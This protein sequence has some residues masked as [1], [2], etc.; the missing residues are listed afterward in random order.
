MAT[1][2]QL[3][4]TNGRKRTVLNLLTDGQLL[5]R[6][7]TRG[8][9]AAFS[10]LVTRH[11]PV[12]LSVCRR[13]LHHA[14]DSEDA[15]QATFLVL[16]R[17]ASSIAKRDSVASWL[18]KVAY[19]IA[20]RARA[21]K[22]RRQ[23]QERQA[24]RPGLPST[25]I[26]AASRE[27]NRVIDEEVQRLPEKYRTPI[28]LCYLQGQTNE[29]AAAR[30]HWPTGT[31]K[32]RLLRARELLRKRLVRRGLDLSAGALLVALLQSAVLAVPPALAAATL[33]AATIGVTS[34]PIAGLVSATL[35]GM[36]LTKLKVALVVL[37]T[38]LLGTLA[39]GLAQRAQAATPVVKQVIDKPTLPTPLPELDLPPSPPSF[40]DRWFVRS[41]HQEVGQ[42]A[43]LP[44]QPGRLATYPTNQFLSA[45]AVA[46]SCSAPRPRQ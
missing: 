35:K 12:V 38:V 2:L 29:E 41:D 11:G 26:E 21:D 46:A 13:I 16:A 10:Q 40:S 31:V 7:A 5:E 15:F 20:L 27:L 25:L 33:H 39:D 14:Q 42:V 32:I 45:R 6:F 3:P 24:I 43:N 9:Q 19:R 23:N 30:L 37:L 4:S 1:Q 17:K 22:T 28:L 8:D 44:L 36:C 18:Y 34:G